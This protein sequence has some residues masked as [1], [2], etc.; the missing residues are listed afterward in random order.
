LKPVLSL[1]GGK[2]VHDA[3]IEAGFLGT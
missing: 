1:G 2:D 3:A